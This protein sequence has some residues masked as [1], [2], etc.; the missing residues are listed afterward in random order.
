[1]PTPRYNKYNPGKTK[2]FHPIN[3]WRCDSSKHPVITSSA[4]CASI[5]PKTKISQQELAILTGLSNTLKCNEQDAVRIAL[6]EASRSARKAHETAF[7]YASWKS[8]EKGHQGRSSERRWNLP[9]KEKLAA[10]KTARELG[11]RCRVHTLV[12]HLATAR[13][14]TKRDQR[15]WELQD[16]QR[17][18]LRT[19]MESG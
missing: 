8:T 16:R 15:H 10:V 11:D 6:Y 5:T 7:K 9:K 19:P 2:G 17:R 1:M 3:K 13:H 4:K 18:Q 12:D 14:Q